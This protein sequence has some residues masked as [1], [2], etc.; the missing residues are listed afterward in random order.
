MKKVTAEN[1]LPEIV[2]ITP[3]MASAWLADNHFD[4]RRLD[5]R[6][7][8]KISRD[9]KADRWVFDGNAIRF[10][11]NGDIIDGQ[12][13]LWAIVM[14][15]K[16]V[17]S[18]VIRNLDN[19]A[20]MTIDSGKA[21]GNAD[22]LHFKGYTNTTVLASVCRLSIGY[23]ENE[24]D[25]WKWAQGTS[26]KR[27]TPQELLH[28]ASN[29]KKIE[30]AV[31]AT[32]SLK[33]SRKI[34]SPATVAFCYYLFSSVSKNPVVVD[35]FFSAF[36]TGDNLTIDSP[37][38]SLRNVFTIRDI[39]LKERHGGNKAMAYRV[40]L[41]IK[42]WNAWKDNKQ[43]KKFKYDVSKDSYPIPK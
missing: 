25:L 33:F 18:L 42:A 3:A 22:F 17:S 37:I 19:E 20:K 34:L 12:H 26:S 43:I 14:S 8:D 10:D 4:N 21:R 6:N 9:I 24:G 40:A 29:N 11:K 13:R 15:G 31:K 35:K 23:K 38:L 7:V 5:D 39:D 1:N 27:L 28:E 16:P 32:Q 36:E 30:E 2:T 41:V